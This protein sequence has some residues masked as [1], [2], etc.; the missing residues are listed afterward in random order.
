[1]VYDTL[2]VQ[3]HID[4]FNLP[5]DGD[6]DWSQQ[7][8]ESFIIQAMATTDQELESPINFKGFLHTLMSPKTPWSNVAY[9][10]CTEGYFFVT[11]ALADHLT[12]VYSRWD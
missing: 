12:V 11:E 3:L 5:N 2:A 6:F 9:I 1:M 4:D 7:H 10:E 8:V